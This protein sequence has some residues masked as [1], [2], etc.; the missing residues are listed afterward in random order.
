MKKL[1]PIILSLII[2][3]TFT[4]PV[5][6][7]AEEVPQNGE[8][9]TA[10]PIEETPEETTLPSEQPEPQK[11]KTKVKGIVYALNESYELPLTMTVKITPSN[12]ERTVKLQRYITSDKKFVTVKKYTSKAAKTAKVKIAFPKKYRKKTTGKWRIVVSSTKTAEKYVSKTIT[13]T[14]RN[15]KGLNLNS[16]TSCVY[17]IETGKVLYGKQMYSHHKQASTTKIMTSVLLIESGKLDKNVKISKAVANTPYGNVYMK[18]GDVYRLSDMLYAM[19]LPSSND[20]AAAIAAGVSK[21]QSKFVELMN[22][23]ADELELND[24]EF[25]NPHGLDTKKNYSTSYDLARLTAYASQYDEF[26]KVIAT[27]EYSFYSVKYRQHKIVKSTDKLKTYSKRHLGGKTGFT[28]GA[29]YCFSSV[30]KY[31]GKHY[32]VNVLGASTVDKRWED[33]KKLYKYIDK[34]ANQ[35]Y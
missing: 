26:M 24:T 10:A 25:D 19:M 30:Y 34:Y 21:S 1:L 13:V 20:C 16:E 2:L 14:T 28:S 23:K 33:M 32:A 5:S 29:K 8:T 7:Y 22:D 27:S 9:T 17:C 18:A 35:K 15:L 4:C 3:I 31:K 11:Q 6:A 12:P